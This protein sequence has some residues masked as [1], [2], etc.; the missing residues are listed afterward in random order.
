MIPTVFQAIPYVTGFLTLAAFALAILYAMYWRS[1]NT[2]EG[3]KYL[4]DLVKSKMTQKEF[5]AFINRVLLSCIVVV[6]V[7]LFLCFAAHCVNVFAEM[8]KNISTGSEFKAVTEFKNSE[9][10]QGQPS[11]NLID[12]RKTVEP[13][14]KL[15]PIEPDDSMSIV[16]DSKDGQSPV[17]GT[18]KV[19]DPDEVPPGELPRQSRS[20]KSDPPSADEK[21]LDPEWVAK[22][23]KITRDVLEQDDGL[24]EADIR[25]R[26]AGR[27]V[28]IEVKLKWN[29]DDGTT[30]AKPVD[31]RL[32]ILCEDIQSP[33][34]DAEIDDRYTRD[35][36]KK[37][38]AEIGRQLREGRARGEL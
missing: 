2:K 25:I 19:P 6:I 17:E 7:G 30:R 5:A 21:P 4:H 22:I 35:L 34:I 20:A 26:R 8:S 36:L 14:A 37:Y 15:K 29:I 23:S 16:D 32:S 24:A 27:G 11:V 13:K 18:S 33:D 28:E 38:G 3:L 31:G 12:G 10:G 9:P 1:V